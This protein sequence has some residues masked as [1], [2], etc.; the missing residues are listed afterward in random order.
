M[1]TL[2]QQQWQFADMVGDLLW[3]ARSMGYRVALGEAWRH[4]VMAA[5]YAVR[6]LGVRDSFHGKRLAIDL[7]LFK[8]GVY[9]A[10]TEA[11][12]P[13]GLHW[14]S[15][16]GTWGGRFKRKDGGHFSLGE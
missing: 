14:E 16:G 1:A 13:L 2:N 12:R 6:G 7:L 10:D 9:L 4:P 15:R 3:T 5:W 8:D 11:Y